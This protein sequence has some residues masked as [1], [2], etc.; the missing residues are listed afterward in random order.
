MSTEYLIS[1]KVIDCGV[2]GRT[3]PFLFALESLAVGD[4]VC[5]V[6][7]LTIPVVIKTLESDQAT[8][9]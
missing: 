1:S 2:N 7:L 6:E 3:I 5:L 8:K 9:K 4:E